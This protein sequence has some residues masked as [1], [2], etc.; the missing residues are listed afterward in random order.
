[1]DKSLYEKFMRE[2]IDEMVKGIRKGQAPFGC[3]IVKNGKM[4]ARAHNTVRSSSDSTAHAEVDALR[5]AEKKLGIDLKGCVLFSSCEPCPMC[6]SASHWAKVD[7]V[8]Y[9][10]TIEDAKS[11]GFSELMLHDCEFSRRGSR[12][13]IVPNFLREEAVNAMKTWKGKPY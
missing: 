10:A 1:M 5:K 11:L 12:I 4:V 8:V 9:A 2:A 7:E 13:K 3:V 6:F